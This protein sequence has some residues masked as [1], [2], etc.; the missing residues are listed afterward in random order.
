MTNLETTYTLKDIFKEL[1]KSQE[2]LADKRRAPKREFSLTEA[3]TELA[4]KNA[5]F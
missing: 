1:P 5:G 3:E 4:L 2:F